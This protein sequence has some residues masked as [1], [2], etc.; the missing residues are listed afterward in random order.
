MKQCSKC[1]R[2]ILTKF[3]R[4][5]EGANPCKGWCDIFWGILRGRGARHEGRGKCTCTA[6]D[7]RVRTQPKLVGNNAAQASAAP[8]KERWPPPSEAWASCRPRTPTRTPPRSRNRLQAP[9]CGHVET[10][11]SMP[12]GQAANCAPDRLRRKGTAPESRAMIGG[13]DKHVR[14]LSGL[15]AAFSAVGGSGRDSSAKEF[16]R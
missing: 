6:W 16:V 12:D 9:D 2:I 10:G 1:C 7:I 13:N 8:A 15:V 14:G 4:C 5:S 11:S 3:Q